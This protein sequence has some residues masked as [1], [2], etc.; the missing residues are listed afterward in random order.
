MRDDANSPWTEATRARYHGDGGRGRAERR[1]RRNA[2]RVWT[3]VRDAGRTLVAGHAG[4]ISRAGTVPAHGSR[5][6]VDHSEAGMVARMNPP[7]WQG[8]VF[9]SFFIALAIVSIIVA[10]VVRRRRIAGAQRCRVQCQE[11][12]HEYRQP[13]SSSSGDSSSSSSGS[14]S[15]SDSGGSGCG[16]CGGGGGD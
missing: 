4:A 9:L 12:G 2:G 5:T 13:P 3:L 8:S 7:D 11:C 1:L 16:G 14:S 10:V 6:R 15:S